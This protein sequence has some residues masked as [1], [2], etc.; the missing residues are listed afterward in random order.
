MNTKCLHYA[1]R[2]R[3]E[4]QAQ[5]PRVGTQTSP[6]GV[7]NTSLRF[8]SGPSQPCLLFISRGWDVASVALAE[9]KK[10]HLITKV[11]GGGAGRRAPNPQAS[12]GA[13][14]LGMRGGSPH[15]IRGDN[16]L[17]PMNILFIS[18]SSV[19]SSPSFAASPPGPHFHSASVVL[20]QWWNPSW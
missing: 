9:G 13:L 5:S 10:W 1:Q 18:D 7:A 20:V 19:F 11:R 3:D 8:L 16:F 14:P 4:Y 15:F 2:W 12:A 17:W 6:P